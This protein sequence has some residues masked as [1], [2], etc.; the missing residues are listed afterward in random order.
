MDFF[1][2]SWHDIFKKLIQPLQL[3]LKTSYIKKTQIQGLRKFVLA[4]AE[5]N[6]AGKYELIIII[7]YLFKQNLSI[8]VKC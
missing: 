4:T 6:D 1:A 7:L 5:Y 8:K 3:A 2:R